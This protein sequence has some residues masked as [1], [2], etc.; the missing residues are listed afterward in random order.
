M[1][2]STIFC[3]DSVQML[4]LL[5]SDSIDAVVTDPPYGMNFQSNHA[6]GGPRY[7]KNRR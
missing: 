2:T 3:G 1:A 6:K 4:E 5:D 7:K